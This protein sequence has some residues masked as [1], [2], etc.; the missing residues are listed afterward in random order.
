VDAAALAAADQRSYL[1][2]AAE[3][4]VARRIGYL[5]PERTFQRRLEATAALPGGATAAGPRDAPWLLRS[6]AP[7]P[8]V[9]AGEPVLLDVN[10]SWFD[11]ADG[12]ALLARLAGVRADLVICSLAEDAPVVT[13]EA[14]ARLR[15]FAARLAG[16]AVEPAP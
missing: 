14:R 16:R 2:S 6:A 3:A 13:A 5:V 4:G 11:E 12:D 7:W 1:W 9:P 15:A 10:A 8:P